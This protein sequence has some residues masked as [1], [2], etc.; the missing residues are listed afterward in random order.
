MLM[1]HSHKIIRFLSVSLLLS[2]QLPAFAELAVIANKQLPISSL[3]QDEVKRIYLG[4]MKF[5]SSGAKVIPVD[6]QVGTTSHN[7][8]YGDIIKKSDSEIKA[9]WARIMFTGQGNP[10]IQ[11]SD[12]QS[13]KELVSRNPNFIGYV[14]K[15]VVDDSVKVLYTLP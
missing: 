9:Y 6:Q 1:K 13:V 11:E 2:F 5:L 12:D 8:F 14:D 15:T 7:K 10:P 4:K 3:S